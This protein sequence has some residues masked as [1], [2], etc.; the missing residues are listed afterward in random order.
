MIGSL[1][2]SRPCSLM[3]PTLVRAPGALDLVSRGPWEPPGVPWALA[4]CEL[5]T[6]PPGSLGRKGIPRSGDAES[7]EHRSGRRLK[8]FP[9]CWN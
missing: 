6:S 4:R 1:A 8:S 3:R 9:N 7:S 2:L 5:V